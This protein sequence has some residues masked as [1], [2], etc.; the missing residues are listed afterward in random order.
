ML[1]AQNV[2]RVQ[3]IEND[4]CGGILR[5]CSEFSNGETAAG[6]GFRQVQMAVKKGCQEIGLILVER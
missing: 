3:R 2:K 5:P 4:A 1:G 6:N